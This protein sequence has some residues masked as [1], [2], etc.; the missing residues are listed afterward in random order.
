MSVDTLALAKELRAANIEAA[1]AEA[2]A[3]A[4]GK[5]VSEGA[6]SKADLQAAEKALR[7]DL[8]TVEKALRADI[9]TVERT[10]RA[11]MDALKRELK[12]DIAQSRTELEVLIEKSK[13]SILIWLVSTQMAFA[14]LIIAILK[15]L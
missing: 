10:L 8:Q 2:I 13:S 7:A 1:H 14:G 3:A 9:Q 11:E 4:I 15:F 12:A 5:S 6:A